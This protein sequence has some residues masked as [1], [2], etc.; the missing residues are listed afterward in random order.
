LSKGFTLIEI[1]I[2][3][4]I[5][6]GLALTISSFGLDISDFGIFLGES[7]TGQYEIQLTLRGM[8]SEMKSMNQSVSGAYAIESVSQNSI[9]FYSDIDGDG[10]TE[11][12]RYFLDGNILKRGL[13]KA[14]GSP[15][16]Y[17]A[18]DEDIDETVHN[19]LASAGNIFSYYDSSYT[20]SQ[21]A[22]NFPV[23]IPLVRLI[24]INITVDQ[25][26]ADTI[27]QINLSAS[28]NIRNL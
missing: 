23:N 2:A 5:F 19:V 3:I 27:S 14:S 26:P 28:V 20:G 12:I 6:T 10:L 17:P 15:L 1:I 18:G 21:A 13:T 24:K 25:N 8:V 7:V 22:L 16:A 4:T 11:K 9:T